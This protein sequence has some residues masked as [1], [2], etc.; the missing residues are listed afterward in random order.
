MHTSE[1]LQRLAGCSESEDLA[2][3]E[4]FNITIGEHKFRMVQISPEYTQLVPEDPAW[5][6]KSIEY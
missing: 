3:G 5:L 6:Y 4:G 1:N 2:V